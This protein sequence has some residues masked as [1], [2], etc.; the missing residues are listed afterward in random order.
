[1]TVHPPDSPI[2]RCIEPEQPL[3]NEDYVGAKAL[4][5]RHHQS[6]EWDVECGEELMSERQHLMAEDERI[7]YEPVEAARLE[8]LE[9]PECRQGLSQKVSIMTT[10]EMSEVHCCAPQVSSITRLG[11]MGRVLSNHPIAAVAPQSLGCRNLRSIVPIDAPTDTAGH[12]AD[13]RRCNEATLDDLVGSRKPRV[14]MGPSHAM[15]LQ[16]RYVG[17]PTRTGCSALLLWSDW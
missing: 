14:G 9:H 6:I 12:A 13:S 5:V 3:W 1:M 2:D 8:L 15:S 10:H 17:S 16:I 7:E 4:P 11:L